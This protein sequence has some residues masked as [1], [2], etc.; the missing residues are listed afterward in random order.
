MSGWANQLLLEELDMITVEKELPTYSAPAVWRASLDL[1][2]VQ[3]AVTVP[4]E[5][6]QHLHLTTI[7]SRAIFVLISW[8]FC[9]LRGLFGRPLFITGLIICNSPRKPSLDSELF[10][11]ATVPTNWKLTG[12]R[13]IGSL[14][15]SHARFLHWWRSASATDI[16]DISLYPGFCTPV[17][18]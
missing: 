12:C 1:W 6:P 10:H 16:R 13:N 8:P 4:A 5:P 9:S 18:H 14:L 11:M 7:L 17:T 15:Q 3:D 2:Q